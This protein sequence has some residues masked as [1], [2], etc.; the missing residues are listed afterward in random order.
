MN[1]VCVHQWESIRVPL[2][3]EY[4]FVAIARCGVCGLFESKEAQKIFEKMY[5]EGYVTWIWKK[6][7][8]NL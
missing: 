8:P 2:R 6:T 5:D 7:I 3:F 4:K 1:Q